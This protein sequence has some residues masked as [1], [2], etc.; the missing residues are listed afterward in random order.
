MFEKILIANWGDQLPTGSA[1]AQPNCL[2]AA[3]YQCD[4]AAE[5]H[6]V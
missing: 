1:A 2:V 6:N 4:F 3:G 5:T